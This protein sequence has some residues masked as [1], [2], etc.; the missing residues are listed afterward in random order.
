MSLGIIDTPLSSLLFS[1]L[2]VIIVMVQLYVVLMFAPIFFLLA[3]IPKDIIEVAKDMGASSFQI[4]RRIIFPL[5]LPG[6]AIGCIF[7]FV[8]VMGELATAAVIGGG[9]TI[10]I[11]NVIKSMV[12]IIHWPFAAV[13][14]VILMITMMLGV[15]LI[16]RVVD[17]RKDL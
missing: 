12:D 10:M 6:I 7:V 4:F 11:G 5:S 3:K 2:A 13:N 14:A 16:L 1:D 9:Q 17:P 8:M 15:W